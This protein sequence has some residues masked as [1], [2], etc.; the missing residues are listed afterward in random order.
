MQWLDI[1]HIKALHHIGTWMSK[2]GRFINLILYTVQ[3]SPSC[4][5]HFTPKERFCSILQITWQESYIFNI[6]Y[7]SVDIYKKNRLCTLAGLYTI[8]MCSA[9]VLD[10][11][12]Y[13][14]ATHTR[15]IYINTQLYNNTILWFTIITFWCLQLCQQRDLRLFLWHFTYK[16]NVYF[17]HSLTTFTTPRKL[18]LHAVTPEESCVN[19]D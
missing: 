4:S 8:H 16:C 6:Y 12:K 1:P 9:P 7:I 10:I 14:H 3:W 19:L 18:M 5:S 13:T 2:L 17:L 15:Y 11:L